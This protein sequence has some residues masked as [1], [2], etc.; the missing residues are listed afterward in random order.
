MIVF[1][2][3]VL[4]VFGLFV[5]LFVCLGVMLEEE[6]NRI[7]DIYYYIQILSSF[8]SRFAL[9]Y[10]GGRAF[11]AKHAAPRATTRGDTLS[12]WLMV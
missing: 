8:I 6:R 5:F 3:C 7:S 10:G 12:A 2:R 1:G 4:V 9:Y 11:C